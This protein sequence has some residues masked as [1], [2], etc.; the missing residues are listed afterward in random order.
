LTVVRLGIKLFIEKFLAFDNRDIRKKIMYFSCAIIENVI[1]GI[2][3][4]GRKQED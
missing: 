4:N 1:V 3:S 2:I